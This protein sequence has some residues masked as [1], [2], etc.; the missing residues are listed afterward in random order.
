VDNFVGNRV[1]A[2]PKP[3]PNRARNR[4]MKIK[5]VKKPY[6]SIS[7]TYSRVVHG[8]L[9]LLEPR[10]AAALNLWSTDAAVSAE[11]GVHTDV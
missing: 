4:L 9:I 11:K 8:G 5:A 6:K 1:R 3:A 10:G 2:A 7:Y